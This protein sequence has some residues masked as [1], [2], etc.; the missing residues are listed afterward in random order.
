MTGILISGNVDAHVYKART[1]GDPAT[2]QGVPEATSS[3]ERGLGPF[4]LRAVKRHPP[5]WHLIL[6]LPACRNEREGISVVCAILFVVLPYS[7]PGRWMC[8]IFMNSFPQYF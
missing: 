3:K 7:S 6:G 2:S 5:C 8:T 4:S 1:P